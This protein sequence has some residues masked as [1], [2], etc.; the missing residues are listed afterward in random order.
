M[1]KLQKFII[2]ETDE[3][4]TSHSGLAMIGA[5][6]DES[7]L[8]NGLRVLLPG[9]KMGSVSSDDTLV[10]MA[11][12]LGL[13]KPD[14]A[15]IEQ[16]RDDDYFRMTLGLTDVPS[17]PTLRQRMDEIATA[18]PEVRKMILGSSA[19]M[20]KKHIPE[21]TGCLGDHIVIDGDVSPFD[22]S[23]SKKEGVSCTYKLMDGYAPMFAY[24]GNEGYL[25]NVELR[26]GKQHCQS[27]TPEFLRETFELARKVT[28][29]RLLI[30][31]DSGNDDIGNIRECRKAKVDFVIKRNLRKESID[32]WLLDARALGEWRTPR[33]GK[34]VYVGET[35]RE[36]D[37][38][39]IRVV[40]EVV[41]RTITREGQVLLVP[42]IEVNT[43][44]VSLGPRTATPDEVIA[45]YKAHG[46]SEQFHSEIKT[47]MDLE[48]LPSGKFA[49]NA[50]ILTL[51]VPVF[52]MLRLCG[53][54]GMKNGYLS[55][56][57]VSRRR[58]RTVIQDMM[59]MAAR[60]VDHARRIYI[61]FSNRNPLRDVWM[62]TY[63]V[64]SGAG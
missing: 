13:A 1:A 39:N 54:V 15:A 8:R 53:Q 28:D 30:R 38:E 48:R 60:V 45:I 34:T 32:E 36:R 42:E 64:F 22:N 44:W 21:L 49:T 59:Y 14:F 31:L 4:L 7:G 18:G 3:F 52:N 5:L 24:I 9:K 56:K 27:G 25:L 37:G 57:K 29:K 40:F 17:E 43:W 26:E 6:A 35:M 47:D 10:S 16:F 50:L 33:E 20:L 51:A 12:L 41:E 55:K 19:K 58:I 23:G 11:G 62:N 46:T 63:L 2:R 61:D